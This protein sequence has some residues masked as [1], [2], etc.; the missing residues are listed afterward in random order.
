MRVRYALDQVGRRIAEYEDTGDPR[1]IMAE[2]VSALLDT[3]TEEAGRRP[4]PDAITVECL[5]AAAAVL[6]YTAS[7][8]EE[9]HRLT[10]RRSAVGIAAMI[11]PI[12]PHLLPTALAQVCAREY[13]GPRTWN[14]Q[15]TELLTSARPG[16]LAA[17]DKA[18]ALLRQAVSAA[19]EEHPFRA[20]YLANLAHACRKRFE[21]SGLEPD[22]DDAIAARRESLATVVLPGERAGCLADLGLALRQRFTSFGDQDALR[23]AIG[24]LEEAV[25]VADDDNA[26]RWRCLNNLANALRDLSRL[27]RA[28]HEGRRSS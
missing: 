18:I 3:L 5:S 17:V 8:V 23:A 10:V 21:V 6:W 26:D 13:D 22:L 16:D 14:E 25:D 2:D 1:G 24:V 7:H 19:P 20:A 9:A 12:A 27:T 11:Y 4:E 28:L 15:A